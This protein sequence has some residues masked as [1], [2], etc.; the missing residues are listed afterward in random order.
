VPATTLV[1]RSLLTAAFLL[2]GALCLRRCFARTSAV[3][4]FNDVTHVV[5]TVAMLVMVWA[6]AV[7]AWSFQVASFAAAS[8][9]FLVQATGVPLSAGALSVSA[10]GTAGLR[11]TSRDEFHR[12]GCLHHAVLMLTTA[13]MLGAAP[14]MAMPAM[15]SSRPALIIAVY[16]LIATPFCVFV[17]VR[18]WRRGG[19]GRTI[20]AEPVMTAAM[21]GMA[22][23]LR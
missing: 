3:A 8:G 7:P 1:I 11:C 10:D 6:V 21:G 23:L 15:S 17:A 12:L 13:W 2:A 22:L 5:M 18:A 16:C 14:G 20:V 19:T 4:R 9:W